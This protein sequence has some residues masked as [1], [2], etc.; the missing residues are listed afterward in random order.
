MVFGVP[1]APSHSEQPLVHDNSEKSRLTI[2]SDLNL[3]DTR[4][5]TP[6]FVRDTLRHLHAISLSSLT[7]PYNDCALHKDA[8]R[9]ITT[10]MFTQ[11]NEYYTLNTFSKDSIAA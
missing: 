8:I 2:T 5:Y 4:Y 3:E 6:M 10:I 11:A 9:N 7:R 1:G